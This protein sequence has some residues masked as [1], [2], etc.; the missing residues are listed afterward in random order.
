MAEVIS[1]RA[2]SKSYGDRKAVDGLNLTVESGAFFGFLGPNGA[3]KT[4]TIRMLTGVLRPDSGMITIDG[5]DSRDR[6]HIASV[7]GVV[8]ESRG[9]YD[10]MSGEEYLDFFAALYRIGDRGRAVRQLLADVGLADRGRTAIGT[11]SRGMKQRLGLARALVN[12]P[13][14]LFLDE[15]TL[16]LDPRGQEDVQQL[17]KR[18][19]EGGVTVFYSSHLLPEVAHLCSVIAVINRG[20]LAAEGTLAELQRK[21]GSGDLRD[22]FMALTND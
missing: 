12:S 14:I 18:L 20:R 15:P 19:N 2:I 6:Q 22:V 10:W 7:I 9:F 8:P 16:G 17:L 11:Y 4:T 5:H 3:G 13:R 1:A 21:T